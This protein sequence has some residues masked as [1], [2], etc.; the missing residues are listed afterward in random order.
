MAAAMRNRAAPTITVLSPFGV[1]NAEPTVIKAMAT[2]KV[3]ARNQRAVVL[4]EE[5]FKVDYSAC[6]GNATHALA[7]R[8]R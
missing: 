4:M 7:K 5:S 3:M 1:G 6:F 8:Q 2:I